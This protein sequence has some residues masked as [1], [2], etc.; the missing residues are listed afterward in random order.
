MRQGGHFACASIFPPKSAD[1]IVETT[2]FTRHL[3]ALIAS[4]N[5]DSADICIQGIASTSNIVSIWCSTISAAILE[6]IT[7]TLLD[8]MHDE[9]ETIR[10]AVIKV[11]NACYVLSYG[12]CTHFSLVAILPTAIMQHVRTCAF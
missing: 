10:L 5:D 3:D 2:Y 8:L 6:K 11:R 9:D 7:T 12:C 1:P 4:L